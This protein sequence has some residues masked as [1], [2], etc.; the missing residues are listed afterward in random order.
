MFGYVRVDKPEM[1]IKE[2][3]TYRG[4]YCSLCKA[5]GKHFGIF[6]RLT[7][8]YDVAFLVL[9]RLCFLGT[10]PCFKSGRCLFNPAKKCNYCHNADDEFKYAASISMMLFYFKVK[11]NISDSSFYKRFAMY[12]LLPWAKSKYKKAKSWYP[13]IAHIIEQCMARQNE[14][15]KSKTSIT[16][17]AAHESA[18]AL[19]KITAYG[20][21]DSDSSIYRFGYGIGKWVY[22]MD[23]ADDIESDI[24]SKS[25]NV[26]IE[27]YNLTSVDTLTQDIKL[28]ITGTLNMCCALC[29]E[30][31]EKIENKTLTPIIENIIFSG[32]ALKM[33]TVFERKK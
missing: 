3:E 30:A 5:M 33:E 20:F 18:D 25:Y 26:F 31:Y 1:K 19:G 24:K 27:K 23:A 4:L 29:C 15:E 11:D 21:D 8:S 28:E 16:D 22:L 12:F 13:E 9:T 2:Y 6:S 17:K 10:G 14:T 7:L 32:M